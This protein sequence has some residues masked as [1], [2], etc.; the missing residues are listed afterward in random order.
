MS[1]CVLR[2]GPGGSHYTELP[3]GAADFNDSLTQQNV[4]K[5]EAAG[6]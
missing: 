1:S 4:R 2:V 5:L 6:A 3:F